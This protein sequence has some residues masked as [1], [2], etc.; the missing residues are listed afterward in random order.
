MIELQF[1]GNNR[2]DVI[3]DICDFVGLAGFATDE[4]EAEIKKR[5]ARTA[6]PKQKPRKAK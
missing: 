1:T 4:L 6:R 3:A 5:K 2:A